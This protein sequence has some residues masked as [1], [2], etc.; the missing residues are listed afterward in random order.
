MVHVLFFIAFLHIGAGAVYNKYRIQ[1]L[2]KYINLCRGRELTEAEFLVLLRRYTSFLAPTRFSPSRSVYPALYTN[3][4]FA[5]FA[6][7]SKQ[8]MVYL[9]AVAIPCTVMWM[10]L[11]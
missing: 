3:E 6:Q 7:Q 11:P 4:K 10:T 5:A 9:Y 2:L 1:Q 8:V